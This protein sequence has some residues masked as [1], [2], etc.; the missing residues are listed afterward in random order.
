M[1]AERPARSR[2][3]TRSALRASMCSAGISKGS[4]DGANHIGVV[5][6]TDAVTR[7]SGGNTLNFVI[8]R[9]RLLGANH[10]DVAV[11][12]FDLSGAA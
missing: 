3:R 5:F 9:D 1:S 7:R 4:S 8:V 11:Q 2:G 6:F 10:H 12:G